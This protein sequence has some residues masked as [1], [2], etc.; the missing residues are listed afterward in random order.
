MRHVFDPLRG[1][2]VSVAARGRANEDPVQSISSKL[3][4]GIIRVA[5]VERNAKPAGR[6]V[7]GK[8]GLFEASLCPLPV[9][10]GRPESASLFRFPFLRV[11]GAEKPYNGA[12]EKSMPSLA[13]HEVGVSALHLLPAPSNNSL[14][15]HRGHK[16]WR[17]ATQIDVLPIVVHK[18][19]GTVD[20]PVKPPR[21]RHEGSAWAFDNTPYAL[22][23]P[24]LVNCSVTDL[25]ESSR[26][27]ECQT[28]SAHLPMGSR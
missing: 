19:I 3:V 18:G 1:P 9:G 23:A 14:L 13:L 7:D 24:K 28:A 27:H 21:R 12:K 26:S 20:S 5:K 25:A 22:A 4:R 2:L 16:S 17:I 11:L 8:T 15:N 6:P 10:K